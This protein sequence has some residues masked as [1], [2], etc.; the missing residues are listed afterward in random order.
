MIDQVLESLG[1]TANNTNTKPRNLNTSCAVSCHVHNFCRDGVI[2][3]AQISN[4]NKTLFS[5]PI[6]GLTLTF[7]RSLEAEN[8]Q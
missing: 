2:L 6:V 3:V 4:G 5:R 1:K 8:V 7:I